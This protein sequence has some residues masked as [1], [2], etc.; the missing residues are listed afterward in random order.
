MSKFT[1]LPFQIK[2]ALTFALVLLIPTAIFALYSIDTTRDRLMEDQETEHIGVLRLKAAAVDTLL[3][4]AHDQ[5]LFLANTP[6]LRSYANLLDE[7]QAPARVEDSQMLMAFLDSALVRYKSARIYDLAGN[8]VLRVDNSSTT[9]V[10]VL[11]EQLESNVQVPFYTEALDLANGQIYSSGLTLSLVRGRINQPLVP[12]IYYS[13]PLF[14]EEGN[15]VGVVVLETFATPILTT[16]RQGGVSNNHNE[17]FA[18]IDADGSYL[19]GAELD[20]MYGSV[21]NTGASYAQDY[22]NEAAYMQ[23][24]TEGAILPS[25]DRPD[26]FI[27]FA[28]IKPTAQNIEW[29]IIIS[30]PSKNV[31]GEISDTRRNIL[32]LSVVALLI[33]T[34]LAFV[35]TRVILRPVRRLA[36]AADVISRGRWDADIPV[37][38]SHDEIGRLS[39]SFRHM[40]HNLE[41]RTLELEVATVKAMEAS[42]IKSEFLSTM[43]HELRTPLNAIIGFTELVLRGLSGPLTDKQKHQLS[44]VHANSVHLLRLIND[45]LDLSKIEAGRMEIFNAPYAARDMIKTVTDKVSSLADEKGLKFQVTID[46]NL[47]EQVT[48][49]R[50]RVEQV[51]INLLSNAFKFTEQGEVELTIR[52]LADSKRWQLAVRD[53]GVGIAPHA[54]EYI[55]DEFRQ[56]DGTSRRAYGGTGLGLAICRNLCRL[57]EGEVNVKSELGKGSIFTVT[58]PLSPDHLPVKVENP[59]KVAPEG[60]VHS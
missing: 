4:N 48:G 43:S 16:I 26:T 2:L 24:H 20:K 27:Y 34:G 47:P 37:V 21:L 28:R 10:R 5:L 15:R 53:T 38:T 49:D 36:E 8:E 42:R 55:F 23:S 18:V 33:T 54:V 30:E 17:L 13:T 12:V 29:T 3:E 25:K 22:P 59:V 35:L 14:S 60:A 39:T 11:D 40:T 19:L 57:M 6:T 46:P 52:H 44:R 32:A 7:G 31:L 50:A 45:I 9:P 41:E 51:V 56:A 58:L 1:A